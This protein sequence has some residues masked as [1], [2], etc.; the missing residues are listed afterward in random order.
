MFESWTKYDDNFISKTQYCR[1]DIVGFPILD[2]SCDIM[3]MIEY[4]DLLQIVLQTKTEITI[5]NNEEKSDC[6]TLSFYSSPSTITRIRNVPQILDYSKVST[7]K[8]KITLNYN[9]NRLMKCL[10]ITENFRD[11]FYEPLLYQMYSQLNKCQLF[12]SKLI[13]NAKESFG[14]KA[15][16]QT[17]IATNVNLYFRRYNIYTAPYTSWML[18]S[19]QVEK[20]M[21]RNPNKATPR[22][23]CDLIPLQIQNNIGVLSDSNLLKEA[24][25]KNSNNV[26]L[27]ILKIT[28]LSKRSS[29]MYCFHYFEK[30]N[31]IFPIAI[32]PNISMIL[33]NDTS[34]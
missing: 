22:L 29:Q 11:M 9:L 1:D 18:F 19:K 25:L 21:F 20:T 24:I 33:I 6:D 27:L 26:P 28:S 34:L 32:H 17:L 16:G 15:S 8:Q 12:L 14:T 31:C 4:V 10:S 13:E 2:K 5:S 3:L 30:Y 7:N 23:L